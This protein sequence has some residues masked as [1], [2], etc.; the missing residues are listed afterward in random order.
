MTKSKSS[1]DPPSTGDGHR[2]LA[3]PAAVVKAATTAAAVPRGS[4]EEGED[5]ENQQQQAAASTT[6]RR[7]KVTGP[8]Y[9]DQVRD[10]AT[11]ARDEAS[12]FP[13]LADALLV[14]ESQISVEERELLAQQNVELRAEVDRQR[15]ALER[16][17]QDK[18][19]EEVV[20]DRR[21]VD[22]SVGSRLGDAGRRVLLWWRQQMRPGRWRRQRG[23]RHERHGR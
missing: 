17:E 7:T 9:K 14:T 21:G 3:D 6:N 15:I 22:G 5:E 13:P 12:L 1:I 8:T 4:A 20:S 11:A 16:E 18:K 23:A 10:A 2:G 19:T